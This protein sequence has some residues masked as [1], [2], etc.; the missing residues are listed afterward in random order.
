MDKISIL[1]GGG[2]D[3]KIRPLCDQDLSFA[4]LLVEQAG[5]NQVAGDWERVMSLDPEG[6]F[7]VE[8]DGQKAAT[9]VYT[10]F[11]DIAW[12]SMVLVD[13]KYR[14]R[15]I[16]Q[17]MFG[18]VL[19]KLRESGI[20]TIRLDATAM[21]VN[22]YKKYGFEEEYGLVRLIR[23]QTITVQ[24]IKKY[25]PPLT[26][27]ASIV[28][29]D[30]KITAT[31][32]YRLIDYLRNE[33]GT[34]FYIYSQEGAVSGYVVIR[35]GRVGWQIG[36]CI[37]DDVSSGIKLLDKALNRIME[38]QVIIDIPVENEDALEWAINHG[39]VEQRRFIRMYAGKKIEDQPRRMFASFGPEKG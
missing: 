1:S 5:W 25:I 3:L 34:K 33:A 23:P 22:L 9:I 8:A 10:R 27:M 13:E 28:D 35:P 16:G 4:A 32:R 26:N 21:G 11:D 38:H 15:G 6:C 36:P 20:S 39:F 24:E 29:L 30:F 19:D 31:N 37:A 14:G 17:M 2:P 12:I 7:V 18:Y